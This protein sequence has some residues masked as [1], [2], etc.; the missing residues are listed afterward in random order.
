MG[1]KPVGMSIILLWAVSTGWLVWKDI[2]PAWTAQEPP[3]VVAADWIDKY[4]QDAQ[5]GIFD[6]NDR[7]VGTIWTSYAGAAATDREDDIFVENVMN[8]GP[9]HVYLK[10]Q[11]DIQGRLD[12]FD[13]DLYGMGQLVQIHGERFPTQFAFRLSAGTSVHR[14]KIHLSRAGRFSEAF[15]PFDSMP[16]LEVGQSWQMQV[17]NPIAMITG[18]GDQFIPMLVRVAGRERRRIDGSVKDCFIVETATAKAWVDVESGVVWEQKVTLPFGQYSV[19]YETF[20]ANL[21]RLT[22]E[23]F[24][25]WEEGIG[26]FRQPV[27]GNP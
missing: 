2:I 15:R 16:D 3:P 4:G 5:F 24:A 20:N 13:A 17:L 23:K 19:R 22:A 11:F 25:V 12:E 18:A 8:L 21:K 6:Q 7:R 9:M 1:I 27:S 14:F 10:S 26:L